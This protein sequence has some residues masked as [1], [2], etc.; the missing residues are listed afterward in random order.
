MIESKGNAKE[1]L[2]YFILI[3]YG[4]CYLVHYKNVRY[5]TWLESLTENHKFTFFSHGFLHI[6]YMYITQWA[7]ICLVLV[8]LSHLLLAL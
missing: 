4:F 7:S 3:E 8:S 1:I 6:L 2:L 5:N